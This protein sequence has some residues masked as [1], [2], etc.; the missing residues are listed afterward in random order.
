M[1]FD[2]ELFTLTMKRQIQ[3]GL[4]ERIVE[5]DKTIRMIENVYEMNGLIEIGTCFGR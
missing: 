3:R 2:K 1:L 5:N 4:Y